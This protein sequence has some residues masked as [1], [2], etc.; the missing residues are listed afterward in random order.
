[1]KLS[2]SLAIIISLCTLASCG[3]NTTTTTNTTTSTS[4]TANTRTTSST[5]TQGATKSE[6]VTYKVP[7][8]ESAS[9]NFSITT[10]AN[11][12]ITD[13]SLNIVSGNRETREWTWKFSEALTQTVVG[14][15]LAD[16]KDI[17]AIGGASLTTEAFKSF[18]N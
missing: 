14:K 8:W 4:A 9:V 13:A 11:N 17:D 7:E 6:V 3:T 5:T 18:I 15:K 16:I 10:D 2:L 12:I 1:M